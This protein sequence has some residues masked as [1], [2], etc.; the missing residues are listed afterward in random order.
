MLLAG[1][2]H[3]LVLGY[4]S[5]HAS[6]QEVATVARASGARVVVVAGDVVDDDHVAALFA[7]AAELGKLSGLVNNAG[8]TAHVGDLAD[9]PV[10]VVRRVVEVNLVGPLLCARRAGR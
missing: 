8:V 1:R 7:S 5:D 9:T 4:L 6:A 2:G 10:A 3:D